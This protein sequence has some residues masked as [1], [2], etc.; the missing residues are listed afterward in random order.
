MTRTTPYLI[1]TL[2][3]TNATDVSHVANLLYAGFSNHSPAWPTYAA[4]HAEVCAQNDPSYCNLIARTPTEIIGWIGAHPQ[5]NG[6]A[7]ELH[8]L[9]VAPTYQRRGIGRALLNAL[10]PILQSRQVST[11]FA[12]SDDETHSTSM[13]GVTLY[14]DPLTHLVSFMPTTH[15][16][17]GFYLCNGFVLSGVIPDANGAGKPDLLFV[18]TLSQ[19]I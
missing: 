15:H 2:D 8:P 1:T 14:P 19:K 10:I 4:A 3:F 11:L 16:A 13:G 5:Y 17:G 7:W 6:H 12:W 18:R 9:V